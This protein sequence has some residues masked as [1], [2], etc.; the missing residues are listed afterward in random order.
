[1]G[2]GAIVVDVI[3]FLTGEAAKQASVAD[4]NGDD[5]PNDYYIRNVNPRLRTLALA[6]D[7]NVTVLDAV[8]PARSVRAD[9]P[10]LANLVSHSPVTPYWLTVSGGRVVKVEQQYLP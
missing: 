3:Q 1:V 2:S 7:A 10:A 8:D 5:V 4:G 6:A 9:V